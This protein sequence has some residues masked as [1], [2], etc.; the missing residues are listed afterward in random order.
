M[1]RKSLEKAWNNLW[2]DLEDEKDFND[3]HRE[4][5]TDFVQSITRFQ[6]CNRIA[7]DAVDCRFQ[8]LN[9][10]EIVTSVQEESNPVV[11]ET[12]KDDNNNSNE[13]S[14]GAS[15]ADTSFAALKTAME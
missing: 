13:S 11:D 10:D 2:P 3:K 4:D 1:A 9:D 15:N 14:K 8:M 7:I 6:E 12:D 5:F